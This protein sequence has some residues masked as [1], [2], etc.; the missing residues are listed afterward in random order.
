[1]VPG[2]DDR[3]VVQGAPQADG[4]IGS[5]LEAY[6]HDTHHCGEILGLHLEGCNQFGGGGGALPALGRS[7]YHRRSGNDHD[8]EHRS[9][10]GC[11]NGDAG[12]PGVRTPAIGI[13]GRVGLDDDLLDFP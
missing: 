1:M 7:R 2:P 3:S 12:A 13:G 5:A 9:D 6:P 4:S 8:D 11:I 10:D